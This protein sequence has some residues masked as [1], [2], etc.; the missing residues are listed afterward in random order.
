MNP[1]TNKFEKLIEGLEE[2]YPDSRCEELQQQIKATTSSLLRADGSPVPAHWSV[3]AVGE[4]VV[5]KDYTFKVCYIGEGTL[6]LE[7]VGPVIVGEEQS[8]G[9]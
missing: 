6:L 2:A 9:K 5:V 1:D 7:P 3:F 8:D 4:H